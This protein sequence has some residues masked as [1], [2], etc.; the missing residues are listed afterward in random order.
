VIH[1]NSSTPQPHLPTILVVEDDVFVRLVTVEFLEDSGFK[2]VETGNAADA[3]NVLTTDG[4]IDVVFSDVQ[5]PG[6][7]DGLGLA[8]WI[9]R[10]KPEVKVLL[11]SGKVPDQPGQPVVAKPYDMEAVARRLK[12]MV[13]H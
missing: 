10:E 4:P 12:A 3:I 5:M 6:E 7:M 2:V 1:S 8:R 13:Q 11:T 9:S